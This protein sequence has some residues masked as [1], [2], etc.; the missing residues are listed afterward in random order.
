[1]STIDDVTTAAVASNEQSSLSRRNLLRLSV[2][3]AG[4]TV[5]GP[6]LARTGLFGSGDGTVQQATIPNGVVSGTAPMVGPKVPK[7]QRELR[8]PPVA[9]PYKVEKGAKTVAGTVRDVHHYKVEQ[10]KGYVD[11]LPAPFPKTEVW[12]YNG[13]YPGP[14][15]VQTQDGPVTVVHNSNKLPAGEG[16]SVHLHSSPSQ[17]AHD[18]HPD[19]ETWPLGT[20]G[21]APSK[22][23]GGPR[24]DGEHVYQYP[25][26]EE[27]RTLWYHDHGMH[28]TA[29]HVYKGLMGFFLQKPSAA[30]LRKF[31]A[32]GKLPSGKYDIPM[33][34]ADMQ[35]KADGT[36]GYDDNGHD[37]LWG[38]VI[39]VN[40]VA[41]PKL[42]VDRTR[43]R[44]R[45]LVADLSRGYNF[46]LSPGDQGSPAPTVT[47]IATEAGLLSKAE[48]VP[49][50]RQGMAE[51]YEFVFDFSGLKPG[52]KVTLKNLAADGDMGQVMQ[53]VAGPD[54]GTSF[55]AVSTAP[56]VLNDYVFGGEEKDVIN[57]RTPRYFLF[58]RKNS[59]WVI[60]GLPWDGRVAA[61]PKIGDTEIWVLENKS[62]GWF[63]PVHIH[64]VDFHI[65]RRNGRPPFAYEKG[66]KDVVFVGPNERVE[67]VM[68]FNAADRVDPN[69]PVTGKYVMHCHNLIHEDNDMMT[70]FD[71]SVTKAAAAGSVGAQAV[72]S[73]SMS[74]M[75]EKG[76]GH[77][78]MVQWDLR[79]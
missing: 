18:G 79:A 52:E 22:F 71:T 61:A 65:V 50:W 44:F 43:Y 70:Q 40:G 75:N 38:N 4:A 66:W 12:G 19:D 48:V 39:L 47:A 78:M 11:L 25:N 10:T 69:K 49:S 58:E 29:D 76:Q 33:V 63:H 13:I 53:F 5:A 8:L 56:N 27:T 36:P 62:G 67:L 74:G 55:P 7:F 9:Q 42:T 23:D 64:L 28:Q 3:G 73:H 32:I 45:V 77:S 14:T 31:P 54:A 16:V 6:V 24:Y 41:W 68:K 30:H 51:R 60:N 17:P 1:M 2:A 37:S 46:Q 21:S 59:E 72:S 20:A 34:V 35:F 57:A 26:G 15:F